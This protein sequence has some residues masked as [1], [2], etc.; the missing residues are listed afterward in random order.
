MNG[1]WLR[2]GLGGVVP[3]SWDLTSKSGSGGLEGWA[4]VFNVVDEQDD[5]VVQGAFRKTLAEWRSS[6]RSIPLS[7]DHNFDA[8]AVIGSIAK[9]EEAPYGLKIQANFAS[10]PDA[11]ALRTKAVEGHIKGLSIF[12]PIY[13]K[14]STTREGRP[15]RVLKEV[16][17]LQVA[18]TPYPANVLSLTTAAKTVMS[19]HHTPVVDETWDA[20]AAVTAS[21][22]EADHK[23]MFAIMRNG[24]DP[25]LKASYALPHHQPG[26]DGPAVLSAVRDALARLPQTQ[27]LSD[28]ERAAA[29]AH[30]QAHLDDYN[31][32]AALDPA[33]EDD[34]RSALRISSAPVRRV[35]ID[36][37]MKARYPLAATMA[38][39]DAGVDAATGDDVHETTDQGSDDAAMYALSLIGESGPS[40]SPG[41]EP[42]PSL[43]DLEAI[44]SA[45]AT[46]AE[47]TALEAE[48]RQAS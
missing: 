36:S 16:G 29:K 19:V 6:G 34:L 5:I 28:T 11:Q 35:A 47:L 3:V 25:T 43:A 10:T 33:W 30:L 31:K 18:L 26:T 21:S 14:D 48:L 20:S 45:E 8:D 39:P 7:K 37:L 17:L 15:I 1:E 44:A 27:G 23:H 2:L 4:S 32:A 22:T 12:G 38:G 13:Q 42:N 24:A 46:S 40:N 9:A 41:S